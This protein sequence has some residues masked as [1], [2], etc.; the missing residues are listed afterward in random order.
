[1]IAWLLEPEDPSLKYRTL[2]ELMGK[3]PNDSEAVE[4]KRRIAESAPVKVLLSKMHPDGYWLQKNPRTGRMLGAGVE[5]GAFGT[6]HYCLSYLAELGM[7]RI[8][9]HVAKAAE[10]YLGLQKSDGDFRHHY[11]CLLGLNI[12]TFIMLGYRKDLRVQKSIDLLLNTDRPD[13]GYLCDMHEGKY[14]TKA[15]ESCFRGSVKALLAFSYLPEYRDH[16]R[17]RR[18]VDYF[19]RREGIFRST[20][21]KEFVNKDVERNSFPIVWRANV[22]EILLALSKT[23]Y[24]KDRRLRRAWNCLDAKADKNGKHIL[25]WT[26]E[27]CPWKVGQRNQPNKWMTFYALL[28]H[29]FKEAKHDVVTLSS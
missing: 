7:D 28:A 17:I 4:C 14:K 9:A 11:S 10:R 29:K 27:Q 19:V 24:G 23:G 26:P 16:D 15:V 25:D 13:G 21:L 8:N 1:M 5:Y 3:S 18:L 6:T 12:R 2:V 22:F 20:D